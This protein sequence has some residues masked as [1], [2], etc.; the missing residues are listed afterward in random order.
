MRVGSAPITWG[1]CE[2]PGWGPQKPWP[3]V[4]DEMAA[5]G[6]A[7]TEL[8]PAG[9]LPMDP[10]VLREELA[11]RQLAMIAAFV[12]VNFRQREAHAASFKAVDEVARLLAAL[13]AKDI[14]LSDE[15][16]EMR[17]AIAGRTS[18]TA[19]RGM[20]A[21]EWKAFVD[22]LHQAADRCRDL[23]LTVSFHPHG[24]TYIE[25]PAEVQ[26]LLESTD[27]DRIRLCLD[28]GHTAFGGGDPLET[29]RRWGSRIG[30][31]HLK[32]IDMDRLR[33]GI[34]QGK[35]YTP[36]AKEGVFVELGTGSLDLRAILDELKAAGY[37]GWLVVE[38][39]RVVQPGEDTLA[40][41]VRNRRYLRETFGL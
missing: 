21:E 31:V 16:D 7:G 15:G 32:D 22:G 14:L 9:Y 4:L 34:T 6:F 35:G 13:G 41:A 12:P 26:R 2:I 5:A 40:V 19:V 1:I 30:L 25:H 33:A 20:T 39:D 23:G 8:G 28:T 37:D 10:A 11:R 27:P 17:K 18:E 36:L 3:E 38:Q 29:V 24:G